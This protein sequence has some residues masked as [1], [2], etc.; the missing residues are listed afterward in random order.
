MWIVFTEMRDHFAAAFLP[1][2]PEWAGAGL[3]L[4]SGWILF[5]N[6]NLMEGSKSTAFDLMLSI[7]TQVAWA[8]MLTVFGLIRF[9]VLAV[10]GFWRRSP[11][12]RLLSA[13]LSCFFWF[14]IALSYSA[15]FGLAFGA[16][17][18]FLALEF[19]SIIVAGRDARIVDDK[20]AGL[21]DDKQ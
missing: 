14:F 9:L 1:R 12:L 7:G 21:K 10:N 18:I 2:R 3:L 16:F 8:K 6:P 20:F 17:V 11:H 13:L 19:S 15:T 5:A 4:I